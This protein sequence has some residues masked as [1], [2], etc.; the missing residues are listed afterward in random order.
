MVPLQPAMQQAEQRPASE[1][2]YVLSY[3]GMTAA[4]Q[5]PGQVAA[6]WWRRGTQP[7]SARRQRHARTHAHCA[8][9]RRGHGLGTVEQVNVGALRR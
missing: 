3:K 4:T 7:P 2:C 9:Q 6:Q 1:G 8:H 5:Q